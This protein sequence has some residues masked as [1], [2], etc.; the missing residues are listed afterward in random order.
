[1]CKKERYGRIAANIGSMNTLVS[2]YISNS[3]PED[4][5]PNDDS[6]TCD[7]DDMSFDLRCDLDNEGAHDKMV[8]FFSHSTNSS[9]PCGVT[10]EH[11]SKI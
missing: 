8:K 9:R 10:P 2:R 7:D 5:E 6:S 4:D 3:E 1:M 11:I